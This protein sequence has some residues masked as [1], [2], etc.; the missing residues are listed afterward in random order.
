[1]G[2][3]TEEAFLKEIYEVLKLHAEYSVSRTAYDPTETLNQIIDESLFDMI[4]KI[5]Q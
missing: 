5:F 1:L 4:G 3:V 2:G